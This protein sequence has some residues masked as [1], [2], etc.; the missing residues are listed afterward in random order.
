RP[1]FRLGVEE[2]YLL[3]HQDTKD[4]VVSPD[5]RFMERCSERIEGQ[6]T[7][8][9]LQCQV[10]VGT[11]PNPSVS[12]I[13]KDLKFLRHT[14]AQLGNEFG[15]APIAT[16][17]HPFSTWREQ[18]STPKERYQSLGGE[19]GLSARRLLICGM[20]IHVEIE[21]EDRRLDIMKQACYFLPHLLA[22]S[23]SSPFWEGL[24]T[25]FSSYRVTVFDSLPRTGLPD[26]LNSF[27]TYR[28]LIKNLIQVGSI[29][30]ATKLWWDIRP[31]AKFPT[32]E[33][34]ITDICSSPRDTLALVATYQS[35]ISYLYSLRLQNQT[36]RSY[37]RTL[38]N[39]NRFRA[40]RYGV[41][42]RL[43]DWGKGELISFADLTEEIIDLLWNDAI[44]LGC[45]DY[46]IRIRNI[47]K[48]GNSSDHQ[49]RIYTQALSEGASSIEAGQKVVE[50][51]IEEFL[52]F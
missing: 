44:E 22:Y 9:Y 46:M 50:Y 2:E 34:R 52:H 20:H 5:P 36:W 35:L 27:N 25:S 40:Q 43:I 18:E 21:E 16:S 41:A 23:C 6:V 47:A 7:N 29:E 8:E 4:L 10:E 12:R 37:P 49:R 11:K 45:Q 42:N 3:V 19:L 51:L 26:E 32:L 30:D 33:L 38:I 15:Y 31:S 24:D 28:E 1:P 48:N 17:T 39:E 13:A 14:I